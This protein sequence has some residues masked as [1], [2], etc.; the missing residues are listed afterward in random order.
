MTGPRRSHYEE[1]EG[2]ADACAHVWSLAPSRTSPLQVS[3][4]L[5]VQPSVVETWFGAA[6]SG[7]D[8]LIQSLHR[9]GG[10]LTGPVDIRFG[11]GLA[12][13]LGRRLARKLGVPCDRPTA[14][15]DVTIYCDEQGLHWD[16]CFD[17][18]T[19]FRS[20]FV[21]HGRYPS[22]GW[23]ETS[24]PFQLTLAVETPDGGW[25]W[26]LQRVVVHGLRLPVWVMP[27]T[28]AYKRASQGAYEFCVAI[29]LP[30][31][32]LLLSYQGTLAMR[33]LPWRADTVSRDSP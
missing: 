13:W 21:P 31:V 26:Q 10:V 3:K 6:F 32:G 18:A 29:S 2:S 19:R 4:P 30:V 9:H 11:R 5:S 20:L 22:G 14:S 12:G 33:P 28:R 27:R 1:S 16:R 23:T 25:H 15:L 7:L 17:G 8:P 24:G